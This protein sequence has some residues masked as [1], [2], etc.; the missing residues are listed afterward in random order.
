MSDQAGERQLVH[1]CKRSDRLDH[2]LESTTQGPRLLRYPSQQHPQTVDCMVPHLFCK[3]LA[4]CHPYQFREV[5][6][7]PTY[8]TV[9]W[10]HHSVA[11][12]DRI[13]VT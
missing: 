7:A 9:H 3:L 1:F 8:F 5:Q 6:E 2:E 4:R 13:E 12:R 11:D 10:R